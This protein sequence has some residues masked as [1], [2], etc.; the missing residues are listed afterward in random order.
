MKVVLFDIDG[1]LVLTGRAGLRAFLSAFGELFGITHP[2]ETFSMAG[3]TDPWVLAELA[4]A[5]GVPADAPELSRFRDVY[6]KHLDVEIEKPGPRKGLMPGV[7]PLLDTLAARDDV[8]LALLTGNYQRAAQLKLEYFDLWRY[9][10]GG[11]FG[12]A[13]VDR[14]TLVPVAVASVAAAG[15]PAI[16]PA[17]AVVVGDTPLDVAC[18]RTVGARAVAVATGS[19][20]VASLGASGADVVLADLSDIEAALRALGIAD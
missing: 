7:R 18:A 10:R 20:D 12:D 3:R 8:H 6:L 11:A 13:A 5:N 14:N 19:Y 15:G 2:R 16:A 4:A 1:T 17:D 9:F